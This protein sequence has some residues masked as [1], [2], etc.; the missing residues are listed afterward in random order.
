MTRD[1]LIGVVASVDHAPFNVRAFIVG[2]V[3]RC[4]CGEV[5]AQFRDGAIQ[6]LLR[7]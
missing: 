3:L 1:F 7:P 2:L 5:D 4:P 6:R